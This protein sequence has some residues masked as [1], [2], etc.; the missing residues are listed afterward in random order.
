MIK[1]L[2]FYN[3]IISVVV[4]TWLLAQ[5]I[6]FIILFIRKKKVDFK[7]FLRTGGMP[8]A[9]TAVVA[10]LALAIGLSCGFNSSSLALA[11]VF[12][13]IV[14]YDALGIRQA[15]GYHARALNKLVL[16]VLK[17]K[18]LEKF[19][20]SLGHKTSEVLAGVVLG[21]AV[22]LVFMWNKLAIP[23]SIKEFLKPAYLFNMTPGS[24]FYYL[25]HCL[26]FFGF[27]VLLGII[28]SVVA[29]RC[30]N[31]IYKKLLSK[32][33]TL[34]L[35]IG[36]IGFLL[37]FFRYENAYFLSSR[38]LLLVLFLSFIIWGIFIIYYSFTKFPF[39]LKDYKEYLRREKYIP[40]PKNH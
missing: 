3:E 13:V 26:I 25:I 27:L 15:A 34:L 1:N 28:L 29:W 39:S 8:S 21:L 12:A 40:R 5:C 10:T 14:I 31:V 6:K 37:L 32:I 38:F 35:T 4:V 36:I 9:H 19:K 11:F 2:W 30:K 18:H 22:P 33:Y 16:K 17:E 7:V 24:S 20:T 23:A